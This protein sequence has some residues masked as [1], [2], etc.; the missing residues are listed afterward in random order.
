MTYLFITHH[1]SPTPSTATVALFSG[2]QESVDC[3]FLQSERTKKNA[4]VIRE[5]VKTSYTKFLSLQLPCRDRPS[6]SAGLHTAVRRSFTNIESFGLSCIRL[7]AELAIRTPLPM[8]VCKRIHITNLHKTQQEL[9]MPAIHLLKGRKN[10]PFNPNLQI[11][12]C[13]LYQAAPAPVPIAPATI[14]HRVVFVLVAVQAAVLEMNWLHQVKYENTSE[15]WLFLI[16][17]VYCRQNLITTHSSTVLFMH[18][19]KNCLPCMQSIEWSSF[20]CS[21]LFRARSSWSSSSWCLTVELRRATSSWAADSCV[22]CSVRSFCVS[23]FF[24]EA[25]MSNSVLLGPS[26]VFFSVCKKKQMPRNGYY[27]TL[28]LQVQKKHHHY[29][30]KYAYLHCD[31]LVASVTIA[32]TE[33]SSDSDSPTFHLCFEVILR[34]WNKTIPKL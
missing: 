27:V 26:R 9:N 4:K 28:H 10:E 17:R 12:S 29:K 30:K 8:S 7:H 19:Q 13:I 21:S 2:G 32:T 6:N 16:N 14:S 34:L 23:F 1:V 18:T 25:S 22:F 33:D 5:H 20:C 3:A 24:F 31:F 11:T 15:Q